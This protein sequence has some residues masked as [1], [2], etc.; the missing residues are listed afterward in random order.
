MIVAAAQWGDESRA[1][2]HEWHR[3][4]SDVESVAVQRSWKQERSSWLPTEPYAERRASGQEVD[5][6]EA[7]ACAQC[8]RVPSPYQH[9]SSSAQPCL[10]WA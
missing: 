2:Q 1:N 4:D 6:V 10:A 8:G 3:W 9:D 7:P 5:A